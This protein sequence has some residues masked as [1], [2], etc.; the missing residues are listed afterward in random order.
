MTKRRS[1]AILMTADGAGRMVRLEDRRFEG[2]TWPIQFEV[3]EDRADTW[4][5]YLSAECTERGWGYGTLQQVGA[6]ENSGSTTVSKP[7]G[8]SQLVIAWERKLHR[9]LRLRARSCGTSEFPLDEARELFTQVGKQSKE[10]DKKQFYLRGQL[11]YGGLVWR[12]ELWLSDKLRLGPPSV[13][14]ETVLLSSRVI[15]VDAL[16]DGI[17]LMNA[18]S[19]F[20]VE[21]QELSVFLSIAL[22][23]EVSVPRGDRVW[24]WKAGADGKLESCDIRTTGYVEQGARSKMPHRGE[25]RAISTKSIKRPDF[26]LRGITLGQDTELQ[27]PADITELWQTLSELLE[28]KKR[29]FLQ[30]GSMWQLACSLVSDQETAKFVFTVSACEALKP[31]EAQYR[32]HNVYHVVE[33][34]LG[35]PSADLLREEWFRPQDVRNAYL[36]GGEFRGSEFVPHAMMPSFQDPSFDQA[37]RAMAVIGPAALIEWLRR[38]GN[39][40]MAPFKRRTSWKR[41]LREKAMI[42]IP[43]A[44]IV[45]AILGYLLSKF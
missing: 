39:F 7:G 21:L 31:P 38:N 19:R 28:D 34:L 14:D 6:K 8:G 30:A 2:G 22:N 25:V 3:P 23:R 32:D 10:G 44:S 45:A 37:R 27:V 41:F 24:V 1:R 12:G 26:S 36:H 4:F 29:R 5:Q 17:D 33:A 15:I 20:Q 42:L 43:A 18:A 13:Q 16:V 11:T 40:N 35:K 9:P